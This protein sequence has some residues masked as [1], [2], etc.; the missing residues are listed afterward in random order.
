MPPDINLR[1]PRPGAPRPQERSLTTQAEEALVPETALAEPA[2]TGQSSGEQAL[3]T[4]AG[5]PAPPDIRRKIDAD[6][7]LEVH[8]ASFTDRLMFWKTPPRPGVV[9]D[10]AKEAQRLQE[11]SA[12]GTSPD[13]GDTPIIQKKSSGGL[14]DSLF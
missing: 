9:V 2:A 14:F 8:D 7:A 5:P 3:V 4:A 13:V 1:P 6:A 10:P 12:L 11:N